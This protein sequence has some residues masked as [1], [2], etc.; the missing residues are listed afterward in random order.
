VASLRELQRA[1]GAA[2]RASSPPGDAPPV[3]PAANF[4]IYRNNS[5]LGFRAAM[6]ATFPVVRRRVGDDYF[7]QLAALY[8]EQHPSRSG[9]LHW[10][11]CDFAAFLAGHLDD[12]YRWLA[13]L[14]RLEWARECAALESAVP[15]IGADSLAAFAPEVLEHVTFALQPSL[16]LIESPWPVFS[17]WMA[18][19]VDDAP[20]VDQSLGSQAGMVLARPDGVEVARLGPEFFSYLSAL[21]AGASLGGALERAALPAERLAPVLG[22]LFEDRLVCAVHSPKR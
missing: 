22:H 15:A 10:V 3:T 9:D 8:R 13:D 1:F 17:V 18:N 19:Q 20:P 14:A 5:A 21:V 2:L 7:A 11:G 6:Q 12:D 4:S 16:R